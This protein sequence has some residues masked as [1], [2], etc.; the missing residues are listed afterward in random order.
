MF[1]IA[2]IKALYEERLNEGSLMG[3][4]GQAISCALEFADPAPILT[5]S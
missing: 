1:L 3:Y 4:N 5:A 2:P